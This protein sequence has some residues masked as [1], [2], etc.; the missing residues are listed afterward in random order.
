M[1]SSKLLAL[2]APAGS[3]LAWSPPEYAGHR[4]VWADA[5][6][7]SSGNLPNQNN[8]H[9][10]DG[11]LGV[12]NELQTYRATPRHVQTSGG[13]TLQLVPW[14]D[15]SAA[16]GGWSSGRLESRYVFAPQ[17]GVR[18][19]AEA[20]IRFGPNP[21]ETRRGMWPAFWL[22]GDAMRHGTG[23]PGCGEVDIVETVNGLPTGYGTVHCHVFP[24]GICNEPQGRGAAVAIPNQND[25]Q[26][27]R[28][29][30]DRTPSAW[31]AETITWSLNG[32]RFHQISGAQIGDLNVWASLAQRPLYFILNVAVGGDWVCPLAPN[33]M[34]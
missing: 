1:H 25:W 15:A 8:W 12:N 32:Q 21:P 14:R 27:W 9:I 34:G 33:F 7:G 23:W 26:R 24:G 16:P 19:A 20:L 3:V 29:E 22:L 30:W 4:L 28:V 11:N 5:F 17:P 2:L 6:G 13:G 18:T 31:Q 10:V